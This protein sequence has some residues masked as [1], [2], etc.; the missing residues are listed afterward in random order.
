ML[1]V[2]AF[3]LLATVPSYSQ[4]TKWKG[5]T[6]EWRSD[7]NWD[8][9]V[10]SETKS[11]ITSI[12]VQPATVP[13]PAPDTART[14]DFDVQAG[15]LL[16]FEPTG[17]LVVH[18]TQFRITPHGTVQLG[19]GTL[20]SKGNLTFFNEGL[21]QA[22]QGTLEFSGVVWNNKPGSQFDPGTSTVIFNGSGSQELIID[23]GSS[24]SLYNLR[25]LS[26]FISITG[27]LVVNGDC[28]IAEGSSLYIEAGGSLTINGNFTGD[29]SSIQGEGSVTLPVQ[30][31]AFTV[32]AQRLDAILHWSTA[33]ETNNYGFE[34]ERRPGAHGGSWV[35]IGFVQGAGT[36]SQ[37]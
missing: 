12:S 29:P 34:I 30:L 33:T 9:G 14:L 6:Q 3:L 28:E 7:A 11:G 25:V 27:Q 37:P 17:V 10:P 8:K 31:S 4:S 32:S 36:S 5:L 21:F 22:D 13:P 26:P 16:Q 23:P 1:S 15:G 20:I 24:F 2:C 19:T 18:G 35:R